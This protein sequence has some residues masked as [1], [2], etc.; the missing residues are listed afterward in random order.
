[1]ETAVKTVLLLSAGGSLL[2][3]MLALLRRGLRRSVSSTFFYYAWLLVLL[4]FLLPVPG[5]LFALPVDAVGGNQAQVMQTESQD[6]RNS[7]FPPAEETAPPEFAS[8]D[9]VPAAGPGSDV[10]AAFPAL[11]LSAWELLGRLWAAGALISF[12]WQVFAALRFRRALGKTLRP[13]LAGDRE[14]MEALGAAE[15]PA[16]YRSGAVSAPIVLGL[17]R[18]ILVLPEETSSPDVLGMILRHELIHYRRGDLAYQWLTAAAVSVHWFNPLV[19][20]VRREI[21]GCC[22]L[23]CDESLL[24]AMS[25][26][27]RKRYGEVLL[28]QAGGRLSGETA[29]AIGFSRAKKS[30]K[31]RLIQIMTYREKRKAGAALAASVLVLLAGCGAAAGPAASGDTV[32]AVTLTTAADSTEQTSLGTPEGEA[33][34]LPGY[35]YQGDEP[36]L[37]EICAYLLERNKGMYAPAQVEI[38]SPV[39]LEVDDSDPED[40]LVWGN[41]WMHCYSLRNTTLFSE[42]GGESPGLMHLKTAGEGY[43]VTSF[44][45]VGDGSDYVRDSQ[46]IFGMRE[47]L[48]ARFEAS[49]DQAEREAVRAAFIGDYVRWNDLPVTQYQDFGWPPVRLPDAPAETEAEQIIRLTSPQGYSMTYDLREFSYIDYDEISDGLSGVGDLNGISILAERH[50]ETAAEVLRSLETEMDQPS[51]TETSL[52]P[53]GC[54]ATMVRDGA[55]RDEVIINHYIVPLEEGGC[56]ALTVRNTYYAVEGDPIV[57]GADPVLEKTL[58]TFRLA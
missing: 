41:F 36:Y 38:P 33:V 19:Y 58:E 50:D 32:Q 29:A 10:T 42:S 26:T 15:R 16:L 17:I 44:E 22:E 3:L 6:P 12:G 35:V 27:E 49:Q 20:W 43:E 14:L 51:R 39:I 8:E 55:L 25:R 30:L 28:E 37:A 4:R 7:V 46:R 34:S 47:G 18:P 54:P 21:E 56:L 23:S 11:P 9:A 13:P 31:E 45:T 57:P 24:R 5:V 2:A 53:D 52:G 48:L 40:I 1:M